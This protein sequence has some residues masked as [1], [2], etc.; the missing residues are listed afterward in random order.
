MGKRKNLYK[1]KM[2]TILYK[3]NSHLYVYFCI[4]PHMNNSEKK[5]TYILQSKLKS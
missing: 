2:P 4:H 5:L 3:K 1:F